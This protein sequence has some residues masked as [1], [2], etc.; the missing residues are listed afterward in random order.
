MQNH[1]S[2]L[3]VI[4][5]NKYLSLFR[6]SVCAYFALDFS[7]PCLFTFRYYTFFFSHI[8]FRSKALAGLTMMSNHPPDYASDHLKML[9]VISELRN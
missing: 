3:S 9:Q 5:G 6:I 1:A 2:K 8:L 4:K 7:H